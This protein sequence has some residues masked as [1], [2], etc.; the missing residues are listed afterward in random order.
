ML[1]R[2]NRAIIDAVSEYFVLIR[3]IKIENPD[4]NKRISA[5]GERIHDLQGRSR[6]RHKVRDDQKG[7]E[8]DQPF[9]HQTIPI[10]KGE[11]GL[12]FPGNEVPIS[13]YPYPNEESI[14]DFDPMYH[15][16]PTTLEPDPKY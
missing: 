8:D 5:L 14:H 13:Q 12:V 6:L 2:D 1:R 7:D 15:D 10:K 16:P 4:D 11:I 3:D 9:Q